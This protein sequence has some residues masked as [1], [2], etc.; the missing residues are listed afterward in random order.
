[1]R[2]NNYCYT[3]PH[4][5]LAF[6]E[7]YYKTNSAHEL[8]LELLLGSMVS[9]TPYFLA[10]LQQ[11]EPFWQSHCQIRARYNDILPYFWQYCSI[12][13][14]PLDQNLLEINGRSGFIA[15]VA[16]FGN[17]KLAAKFGSNNCWPLE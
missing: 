12:G 13:S 10:P 1:M 7:F 17:A 4:R 2:S 16:K 8:V 11:F 14:K 9:W 3:Y 5:F 6:F 15:G